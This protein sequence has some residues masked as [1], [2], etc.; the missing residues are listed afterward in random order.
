MFNTTT[1]T[2]CLAHAPDTIKN[3]LRMLAYLPILLLCIS[4]LQSAPAYAS[5]GT[6][7]TS[8]A[9]THNSVSHDQAKH[10]DMKAGDMKAGEKA[11]G[12]MKHD[13]RHHAN[14]EHTMHDHAP[15]DVSAWPAK[16]SLTLTAYKDAVSG[17]NLYIDPSHFEFAPTQVNL[18]NEIG[19]GHAHLYINNT[20][21]TRLYSSWYYLN[22]LQPGIHTVTVSL[23]AND[24]GPLVLNEQHISATIEVVQE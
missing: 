20:K 18:K 15:V 10:S 23:N 4:A 22:N 8:T 16:P 13:Q 21:I 14:A 12:D 7:N 1:A 9:N 3:Q 5:D 6:E 19:K 24:H 11:H 2:R 17:W